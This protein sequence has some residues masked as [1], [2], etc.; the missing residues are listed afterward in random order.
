[1]K[2]EEE[3]LFTLQRRE[4]RKHEDMCS[5]SS[6]SNFLLRGCSARRASPR[7]P[8]AS[9]WS[10]SSSMAG[11]TAMDSELKIFVDGRQCSFSSTE[12]RVKCGL[13]QRERGKLSPSDL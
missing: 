6:A 11:E 5:S 2:D 13:I 9:P 8:F 10:S 4:E 1:M 3:E 12:S 7:R